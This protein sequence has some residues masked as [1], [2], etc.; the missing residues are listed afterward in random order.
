MRHYELLTPIGEGGMGEVY[1]ALDT[2]LQREVAIKI[3]PSQFVRDEENIER[4]Y[5]EAR[6]AAQLVHPN[7]ITIHDVGE[8]N[9]VYYIVME[10]LQGQSLRDVL[11]EQSKLDVDEAVDVAIQVCL[12]LEVAHKH[13]M[14]HRDIKPDNVMV[15]PDGTVKVLDFGIARMTTTEALTKTG[16]ILGTVEYMAPEQ[17]L[18]EEIDVRSDLYST[19]VVLYEMLTGEL[20]FTGSTPANIVYQQLEECPTPPAHINSLVPLAVEQIVLKALSKDPNDRYQSVTELKK[21][22]QKFLQRSKLA[23][24]TGEE[25]REEVV[26]AWQSEGILHRDF[27]S[28]LIGREKEMT[29]V[30]KYVNRLKKNCGQTIFVAG[31]A[32]IGK[33]RFVSE[34][35]SYAGRKGVLVLKGHCLYQEGLEPYSPFIEAV[36]EFF[37]IRKDDSPTRRRKMKDF[38]RKEAPEL[39][40]LSQR[41]VTTIGFSQKESER[42]DSIAGDHDGKTRLFEVLSQLFGLIA[43][44][45]PLLLILEDVHWADSASLQLLH[46]VSRSNRHL[47]LLIVSTY[48]S[49]DVGPDDEGKPHSLTETMQRMSREGLYER[50]ELERLSQ[51]NHS[52]LMKSLFRRV[53]FSLEF[54][55]MLYRETEGNPFFLIETLRL[56]HN[57][58]IVGPVKGIWRELK[59]VTKV[60]IP[61]RVYDVIRGR[62]E[63]LDEDQRE[64]LQYAAVV[65]ERFSSTVLSY[66]LEMKKI[67]LLK[68]LHRLERVHQVILSE[69]NMFVFHH[70]KIR[71]VLYEEIPDEL[72]REYHCLI[73][74]C[75]EDLHIDNVD[76]VL[77]DLARHFYFGKNFDKAVT[78]LVKAGNRAAKLY[79]HREACEHYERA[80]HSLEKSE[81][82]QEKANLRND[83]IYKTGIS[84]DELGMWDNALN[85]F[86]VLL[87]LYTKSCDVEGEAEA[88]RQM[89]RTYYNKREIDKALECYLESLK[90]FEAI[91]DWEKIC[92]IR[93]NIG[94]IYYEK[95]DLDRTIEEYE[96]ALE[97]AE[98]TQDQ[99]EIANVYMNLGIVQNVK[100]EWNKALSYYHR[101]VPIYEKIGETKGLARMYHN[102]A[103][104]YADQKAW[105]V[106]DTYFQQSLDLCQNLKDI[107]LLSLTYLN[108]TEVFINLADLRKAKESCV[109]AMGNFDKLDDRL[110]MADAHRFLGMIATREG[111]WDAA[112]THFEES[113]RLNEEMENPLGLAEVYREY[114]LMQEER[115]EI[116]QSFIMLR[117]SES[118]FRRVGAIEDVKEIHRKIEQL[119][120]QTF[121]EEVETDLVF[122]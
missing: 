114:G 95:G 35:E 30:R 59:P 83:I 102:M 116:E 98:R 110:G 82:I 96:K 1:K 31:E 66:G 120:T 18:G 79:A 14:L 91:Q 65:G 26:D 94:I 71:E 76:T 11:R 64:L 40:A 46:Y 12:A 84:Y 89:G 101:C 104:T 87:E 6:A 5:R 77:N 115:E 60:D 112:T 109:L 90:H 106:S 122:S 92:K 10:F 113:I 62:V 118:L 88:L 119:E 99:R 24:Q 29:T 43:E 97:I 70:P 52:K 37:Q 56:L 48:R 22:F 47:P 111:D 81:S 15:M 38:I 78:Y 67:H 25:M 17:I 58:K 51:K 69:G 32:G 50:I 121:G 63:R 54:Q 80:L 49:E 117:Q 68:I 27:S 9:N 107:V 44:K 61:E 105:Q 55:D 42:E 45:G 86:S 57:K 7:V 100:G 28:R 39:M 19:G 108:R 85:T 103:M 4:F 73:G 8:E 13:N 23:K 72:R 3:L 93:N 53:D 36:N 16:D 20:P 75:L 41:F 74:Q 33:T 21:V 2:S 34:I